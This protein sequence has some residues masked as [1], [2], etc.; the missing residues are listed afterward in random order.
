MYVQRNPILH[1]HKEEHNVMQP[2]EYMYGGIGRECL[3]MVVVEGMVAEMAARQHTKEGKGMGRGREGGKGQKLG[4]QKCMASPGRQLEWYRYS[5]KNS[6][7]L[8]CMYAGMCQKCPW[9]QVQ[10]AQACKGKHIP[11]S[12]HGRRHRRHGEVM[13]SKGPGRQA[14]TACPRSSNPVSQIQYQ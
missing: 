12:P 3:G 6:N 14:G 2:V 5:G 13:F 7:V 11:L 4:T 1:G 10:H 8:P 9:W